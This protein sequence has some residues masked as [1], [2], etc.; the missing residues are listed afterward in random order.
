[1]AITLLDMLLNSGLIDRDQFEEALRNRVLYGG[2]IGTSLIE[3][4]FINEET[5]A[6]FLSNK[7][8][9]PYVEPQK[10]L[11]IPEDLIKLFPR[12]LAVKY[13]VIPLS[14]EKKRLNL[15]M[16]DPADLQA[17]DEIGF[18]TGFIIHPHVTPEV[19]LAQAFSNYYQ[20][21]L[22]PRYQH[23]FEIIEAR[24]QKE[25]ARH[26]EEERQRQAEEERRRAEEAR[27]REAEEAR[28]REEEK[29]REQVVELTDDDMVKPSPATPTG[30]GAEGGEKL[31]EAKP[32][33]DWPQQI[34]RMEPDAFSLALAYADSSDDISANLVAWL[35]KKFYRAAL[36]RVRGTR[37]IGW[38]G[39]DHGKPLLAFAQVSL[40]LT[41]P[42]VL[43]TVTESSGYYLGPLPKTPVNHLL[44]AA[45]GGGEPQTLLLMPL[46]V[47]GRIV[48]ILCVEESGDLG[49]KLPELQKLLT[50]AALAFEMLI[51]RD[52]ILML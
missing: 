7:L 44:H 50:K 47:G 51:C 18:I 33:A 10:L 9:V 27:Q 16:A 6:R 31:P 21:E 13:R 25:E 42:S 26:R 38:K 20:E 1:M 37:V 48:G 30:T 24:R 17:I 52:K 36:F 4:G 29:R 43:K 22:E 23:I 3:L 11:E 49:A 14:L 19:R 5:L 8:S 28:R 2:K 40:P 34:R 35:G 45:L 39:I 46:F 15:V 32:A 12:E 41:E